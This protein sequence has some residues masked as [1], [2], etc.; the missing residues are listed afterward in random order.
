MALFHACSVTAVSEKLINE[1][2]TKL[3]RQD[4]TAVEVSTL[5]LDILQ[6]YRDRLTKNIFPFTAKNLLLKLSKEGSINEEYAYS[7]SKRFFHETINYLEIWSSR[8]V[9]NVNGI[10]YSIQKLRMMNFRSLFLF[11]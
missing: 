11:L 6:K 10:F 1:T 9:E 7:V 2:I 4:I 3:E 5:Y 8:F